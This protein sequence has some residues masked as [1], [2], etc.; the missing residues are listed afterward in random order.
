[1][2]TCWSRNQSSYPLTQRLRLL[3]LL[4]CVHQLAQLLQ[5]AGHKHNDLQETCSLDCSDTP[6]DMDVAS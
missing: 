1:M 6:I 3:R 5:P 2:L 4:L